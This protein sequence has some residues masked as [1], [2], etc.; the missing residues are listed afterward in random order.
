MD[1]FM[2]YLGYLYVNNLELNENG[3]ETPI[4]DEEENE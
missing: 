2:D 4:E 1:D 3:E